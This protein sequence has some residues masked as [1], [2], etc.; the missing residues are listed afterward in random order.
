MPSGR[1]SEL[2]AKLHLFPG[3][4]SLDHDPKIMLEMAKNVDLEE[5]VIL[6]LEKDG[7]FFFSANKPGGPDVL[8]LLELAKK[9]LLEMGD[10]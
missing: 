6:G 2:S 3:V 7:S 1:W 4:T 10:P 5:V 8:W 9:R